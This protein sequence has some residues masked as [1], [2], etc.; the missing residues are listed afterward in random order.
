MSHTGL[1]FS[2]IDLIAASHVQDV[3]L[4]AAKTQVADAAVRRRN[5]AIN[6]ARLITHL[7]AHAC[8]NVQPAFR[9]DMHSV[10]ATVVRC[11]RYVQ[12]IELLFVL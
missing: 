1:T 10:R 11:I 2:P 8:G 4:L 6:P 9:I 12:M 5:D 3:K 7:D